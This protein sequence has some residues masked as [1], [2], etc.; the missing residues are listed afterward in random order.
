MSPTHLETL[1]EREREGREGGRE[2]EGGRGGREREEEGGGQR[3]TENEGG[4]EGGRQRERQRK[5]LPP[6]PLYNVC[7]CTYHQCQHNGRP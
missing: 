6:S 2:R 5:R 1:R 7:T 4:R 3:G